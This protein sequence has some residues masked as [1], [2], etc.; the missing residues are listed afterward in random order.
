MRPAEPVTL[1][2]PNDITLTHIGP[3]DTKVLGT[4]TILFPAGFRVD[5]P[6]LIAYIDP[7]QVARPVT[8]DYIFITHDHADHFSPADIERL[9]DEETVVIGPRG[10]V[11]KLKGY[12]TIKV[13]PGESVELDGIQIETV[14]MYN[15]EPLFLWITPHPEKADNVGYV[16]TVNG[17]RIYHAGDTSLL[18]ALEELENITVVLIPLDE[19]GGGLTM[20]VTEAATLVNAIGPDIVVPMHYQVGEGYPERLRALVDENIR[21]EIME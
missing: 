20:E 11:K 1:A 12:Q 18:P 2:L 9:C 14:P 21:V 10:V 8:A 17:V 4:E 19:D 6:E 5:T 16:L 3:V 7:V 13:A 15:L